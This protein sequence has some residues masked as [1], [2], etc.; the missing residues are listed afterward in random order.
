MF[1]TSIHWTTFFYL[2][3]DSLV[4]IFALIQAKKFKHNKLN[5]YLILAVLFIAYNF[6]GGFL[7]FETFPGPFILQYIISYGV[8]ITTVIYLI[9][10]MY[11]EY[12]IRFLK[13]HLTIFNIALFMV[14]CF[15]GLFLLPFYFTNSLY[16]SRVL[17][18]FPTI[19][20]CF[21]FTWAFYKKILSPVMRANF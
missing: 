21:Y 15:L 13:P 3:I 1:N 17:F 7:P 20:I 12:N 6:T 19:A 8:A 16:E 14:L 2:L 11:N 9:Y 5:R 10:Y 4:L 18:I